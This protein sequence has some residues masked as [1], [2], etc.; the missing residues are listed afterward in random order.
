MYAF[1]PNLCYPSTPLRASLYKFAVSKKKVDNTEIHGVFF[2]EIHGGAQQAMYAFEPNLCY[3]STLLR[4]TI[5]EICKK[6]EVLA[7]KLYPK[8]NILYP[9]FVF[10]H[11]GH[12]GL[13]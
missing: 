7:T 11:K 10:K 9:N 6:K 1:E 12:K 13:H 2:T 3:P 5:C 8:S 4:A